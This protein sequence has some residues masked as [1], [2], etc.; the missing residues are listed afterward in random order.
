MFLR[1]YEASQSWRDA[2]SRP[3]HRLLQVMGRFLR[4]TKKLPADAKRALFL[5]A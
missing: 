2:Q 5:S 3:F 1:D 4:A